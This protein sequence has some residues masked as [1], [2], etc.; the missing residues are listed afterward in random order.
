M[1]KK[2]KG[3]IRVI[4]Q[5]KSTNRPVAMVALSPYCLGSPECPV[6]LYSLVKKAE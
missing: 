4:G 3:L 2:G 6:C 1:A 5:F